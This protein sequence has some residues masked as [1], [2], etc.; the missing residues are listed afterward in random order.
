MMTLALTAV[1]LLPA[2]SPAGEAK[3][4]NSTLLVE[5]EELAKDP[6]RFRVLDVR[7]KAKYEDGHVPGSVA[8][9]LGRWSQALNDG[10]ADAAFWKKELAAVGVAPDRP[11]VVVSDD[12]RDEARGWWLLTY[13]GVHDSRVLNG[14]WD[15]YT[16][17][18]GPVSKEQTAAKAEPHDWKPA[19]G[20][21][22]TKG[23]LLSLLRADPKPCIVDART[24][25]EYSGEQQTAKKAGHVPGAVHLE[26]SDL[27]DTKAKKFKPAAKLA[28]LLADRKIDVGRPCVTYCQSGGRS[29]VAAFGLALMG[30]K[31]VRNYYKSWS[32][33][34][35]DPDT[36]VEK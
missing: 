35:N 21:L 14:G 1:Y 3:Y 10:R 9:Q 8:T 12:I 23:D 33:W 5:P 32:E 22:A 20:R 24:A 18:G 34:G 15:A 30:G 29:S 2:A 31:D 36:S 16:A 7:G 26:W 28:K 11:V 19:T 13:A 6:T 4:A 25:E 27:L 17:A